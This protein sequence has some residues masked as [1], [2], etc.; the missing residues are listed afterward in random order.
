MVASDVAAM[1][2]AKDRRLMLFKLS[3]FAT[4]ESDR[5]T[6]DNVACRHL[7]TMDEDAE[8][9]AHGESIASAAKT[10]KERRFVM[11]VMVYF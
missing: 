9:A 2:L 3:S 1:T 10:A 8:N 5:S 11:M 4:A 7:E 6:A